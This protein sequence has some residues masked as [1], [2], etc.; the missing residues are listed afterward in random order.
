MRFLVRMAFWL[1]VV[2]VLLP[3][4]GS[5]PAPKLNINPIDAMSA[6]QATVTDM[7]SFCGRQPEACTVGSQA[8]VAIGHRAQAGAKMLYEYLSEHF[9]PNETGALAN[10]NGKKTVARPSQH[11]LLQA[12]LVPAWRGPQPH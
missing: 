3:I 12:D 2:L 10:A 8:A 7:R 4:G 1:T 11:T 5:G 6:A 9:G